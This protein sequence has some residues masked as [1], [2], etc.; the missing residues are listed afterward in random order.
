MWICSDPS[1]TVCAR[2]CGPLKGFAFFSE[3][4]EMPQEGF[5]QRGGGAG[6][7]PSQGRSG[8]WVEKTRKARSRGSWTAVVA[9]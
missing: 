8:Y 9:G 4:E 2:G 6:L 3:G 5:G 7:D 1:A